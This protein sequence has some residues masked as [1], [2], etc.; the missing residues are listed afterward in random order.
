MVELPQAAR[1]I[2]TDK[3]PSL[4]D[5]IRAAMDAAKD[6][7]V[8]DSPEEE[9]EESQ[10]DIKEDTT[11]TSEETVSQEA[12]TEE[13]QNSLDAPD[14]W[15]SEDREAFN[16]LDDKAKKLYLKRYKEM[17]GGFT[18]KTQTL[19]EERK[20]AERFRQTTEPFK[21]YFKQNGIDEFEAFKKLA[22]THINLMRGTP[23]ERHN[24][25]LRAA[26]DYGIN[27]NIGNSNQESHEEQQIDPITQQIFNK[28]TAQEQMLARIE[29]EKNA[30]EYYSL[31]SK[32]NTF[33][34]TKDA[35]GELKYP[36]FETIKT[37]MGRLLEAG[38][39]E[40]LED[41]YENAIKLNNDLHQEYLNRQY[42]SRAREEDKRKKSSTSK[43]V[44]NVKG[45]GHSSPDGDD[46]ANLDRRQI[47]EKALR[48]QHKSQRI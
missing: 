13:P 18:K 8:D 10:E 5:S 12:P 43:Q 22:Q 41:A 24:L 28:L 46:S 47:I 3:E 42:N 37:E 19:A 39:A 9:I 27:L 15:N 23:Q 29:Q 35:N 40:N 21:D 17:E 36:H 14:H 38:L 32:I 16:E 48:A 7:E 30:Q 45:G 11:E 6:Q 26:Q 1:I 4:R 33:K 2:M 20:I 34:D 44:L 31:Q 25:L